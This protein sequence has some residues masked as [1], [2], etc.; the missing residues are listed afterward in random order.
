VVHV[1]N[2]QDTLKQFYPGAEL[3]LDLDLTLEK[4]LEREHVLLEKS[5]LT[6]SEQQE[7]DS[8]IA[9]NG[10][11]RESIWDV[12]DGGCS[13]YCGGGNYAVSTSSFLKADKDYSYTGEQAND[14]NYKTAWVEGKEGS[15]IG[16]YLEYRFEN[17]SPRITTIIISNGY[18]KSENSW[19]NNNRVKLL[20]LFVNDKAIGVIH[21]SDTRADQVFKVGVLGHNSDGSDLILRF[22]ILD[23]YKG[24]KFDDTAITEIYF[25]GIDVH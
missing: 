19:I 10:E 23:I 15:G 18:V 14:L 16:E 22:E 1:S 6:K 5:E 3:F 12:I 7:L 2:A 13:W 25:D 20:K 11:V 17:K 9:K 4:E 24:V 8:L 21:L